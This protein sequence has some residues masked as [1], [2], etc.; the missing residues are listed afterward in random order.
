[1]SLTL[2][3]VK[4]SEDDFKGVI[5]L[6]NTQIKTRCCPGIYK[7]TGPGTCYILNPVSGKQYNV[8]WTNSIMYFF[9]SGSPHIMLDGTMFAIP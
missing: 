4:H 2:L 6:G 1:M 5:N 9:I 7:G 8:V 3:D